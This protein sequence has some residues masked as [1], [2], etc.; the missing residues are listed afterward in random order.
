MAGKKI[1]N[2][3][4]PPFFSVSAPQGHN[5]IGQVMMKANQEKKSFQRT[6]V[7]KGKIHN[8]DISQVVSYFNQSFAFGFP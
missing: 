3:T 1:E 2:F 6:S 8:Q 4:K 7:R 5:S